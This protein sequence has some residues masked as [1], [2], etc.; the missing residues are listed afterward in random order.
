MK[1]IALPEHGQQEKEKVSRISFS[2]RPQLQKDFDRVSKSMGYEERS[3]ALQI[4]IQ[5]LINDYE[6]KSSPES[7]ATGTIL[8]IYAHAVRRID[9]VLTELGHEHRLVIVSSLHLHLDDGNCLNIIVV[10][11]KVKDITALEQSVRKVT[12]VRQLSS[13]FLAIKK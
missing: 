7:L 2:L 9:S 8:I 5:N 11:G 4:A 10:R 1:N 3:K 6:L 13:A 12:G